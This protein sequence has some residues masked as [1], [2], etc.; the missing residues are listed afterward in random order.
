MEGFGCLYQ[1]MDDFVHWRANMVW[2]DKGDEDL[3]LSML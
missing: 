2:L 1:Q 3:P